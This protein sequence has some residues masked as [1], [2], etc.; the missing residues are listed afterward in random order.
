MIQEITV[1]K[2]IYVAV[3]IIIAAVAVFGILARLGDQKD[4]TGEDMTTGQDIL[5]SEDSDY[6][7]LA[8]ILASKLNSISPTPS[9]GELGWIAHRISF[10]Q[11]SEKAYIE[12]TDTHVALKLLLGYDL[13]DNQLQTKVL[14]TFIPDEF[15]SWDLQ[16]GTDESDNKNLNHY[17]FDGDSNQ[18]IP[19]L[20]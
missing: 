15:G 18:W 9:F 19:E 20:E 8:S 3:I 17:I 6:A 11:G 16:F 12:Y 13:E 2:E 7:T 10:L 14:A 1:K 4:S 5:L